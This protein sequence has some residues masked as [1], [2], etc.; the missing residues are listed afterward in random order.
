[1]HLE[2]E[3]MVTRTLLDQVLEDK[4]QLMYQKLR[5]AELKDAT[6]GWYRRVSVCMMVGGV[7]LYPKQDLVTVKEQVH[8]QAT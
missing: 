3:K 5:R 4:E 6:D 2:K 7:Q 8:C 1:M